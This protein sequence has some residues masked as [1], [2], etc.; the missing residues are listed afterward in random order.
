MSAKPIFALVT[1]FHFGLTTPLF[2]ELIFRGYWWERL[3]KKTNNEYKTLVLTS[4]FFGIFHFGY[5]F[6]IA[7]TAY[8]HNV[9]ASF[10]SI[11]ITKY[12]TATTLGLILGLARLKSK[13]VSLPIIIHGIINIIGN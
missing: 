3:N 2:E 13:D 9:N 8:L 12:I 10:L 5:Y 1:N 4:L 11:M 7:Y 6:L